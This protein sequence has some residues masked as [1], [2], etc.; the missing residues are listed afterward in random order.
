MISLS[1]TEF[2]ANK[3]TKCVVTLSNATIAED[4][5]NVQA[6]AYL[7]S[8]NAL[9]QLSL[10]NVNF[11]DEAILSANGTHDLY[12][13][14]ANADG[15][16]DCIAYEYVE[17]ENV[18]RGYFDTTFTNAVKHQFERISFSFVPRATTV[19]Y[20]VACVNED[21]QLCEVVRG[22]V[23]DHNFSFEIEHTTTQGKKVV[24]GGSFNAEKLLNTL[25]TYKVKFAFNFPALGNERP[26]IEDHLSQIASELGI[27]IQFRGDSFLPRTALRFL[28]RAGLS[29]YEYFTSSFAECMSRLFGW[30]D[31][32]PSM[33]YN[34]F[35]DG[36][37]LYIIERGYEENTVTLQD[38]NFV[39][40]P[41]AEKN[42][43]RTEWSGDVFAELSNITSDDAESR[44]TPFS[45]TVAFGGASLTYEDGYLVS[46]TRD[47]ATTTYTYEEY[48]NSKYLKEKRTV[49][50]ENDTIT[51]TTCNYEHTDNN[52]FLAEE[53]YESFEG[54]F[55]TQNDENSGYLTERRKTTHVPVGGGWYGVTVYDA[56][57]AAHVIELS[58]SLT[59]GA[60]GNKASQ[61]MIDE[62]NEAI[63]K[64]SQQNS[65]KVRLNSV[66]KARQS[67]P[68]ADLAT[69]RKIANALDNLEKKTEIRLTAEL[70]NLSHVLNF[71]DKIIYKNKTYYL[72]SNNVT[73]DYNSIRQN[74]VLTRFE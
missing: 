73:Q 1:M 67:Y 69:L 31:S 65:T 57:D 41:Q 28:R 30:S 51:I 5:S 12:V 64:N 74:V 26:R 2:E 11:S 15:K 17:N 20:E 62:Q 4:E 6:A 53:V 72:V 66:A 14:A 45:G 52:I 70:V 71:N 7:F 3:T 29:F 24:A 54:P 27:N 48:D 56:T 18:R 23:L 35:V 8:V 49:N 39:T 68:V 16:I 21:V 44:S 25:F 32:V 58:T 59:Q 10:D 34:S 63:K 50:T 55:A 37:T 13:R 40:Y 36:G 43:R 9:I 19:Q 60:A 46:E 22:S 61:Y 47:N 33:T 38:S 42:V